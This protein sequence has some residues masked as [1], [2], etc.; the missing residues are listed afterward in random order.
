[1][2]VWGGGGGRCVR[3]CVRACQCVCVNKKKKFTHSPLLF[4]VN[5]LHY[6]KE[7]EKEKRK[8]ERKKRV[9]VSIQ[10]LTHFLNTC[11]LHYEKKKNDC[12]PS[13]QTL[14][15]NIFFQASL[16]TNLFKS[17]YNQCP[18]LYIFVF[19]VYLLVSYMCAQNQRLVMFGC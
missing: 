1:M 9:G 11:S 14:S 10:C 7:N 18:P 8:K 5:L 6:K 12:L 19:A 4:T 2:C 3:A 16:K 15:I 13:S 17:A